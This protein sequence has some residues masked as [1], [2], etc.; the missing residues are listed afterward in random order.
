MNS[1]SKR[2]TTGTRLIRTP[3]STCAYP[4]VTTV[5]GYHESHPDSE[6]D[7]YSTCFGLY[8]TT[9]R[10]AVAASTGV[11]RSPRK[12]RFRQIPAGYVFMRCHL[13]IVY[14]FPI[15]LRSQKKVLRRFQKISRAPPQLDTKHT[16][17]MKWR[18]HN[19]LSMCYHRHMP[20]TVYP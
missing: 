10:R 19:T 1:K 20:D 13:K 12:I 2:F 11:Y 7:H 14:I 6:Y 9:T 5:L 17:T 18:S 3:R 15:K 4:P 16:F 8:Q